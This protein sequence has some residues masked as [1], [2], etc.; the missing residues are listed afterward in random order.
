MRDVIYLFAPND[1]DDDD[2]VDRQSVVFLCS[3]FVVTSAPGGVGGG[4]ALLSVA[5]TAPTVAPARPPLVACLGASRIPASVAAAR[6][7]IMHVVLPPRPSPPT[8][9]VWV[10]QPSP[11]G[12]VSRLS[13]ALVTRAFLGSGRRG[14]SFSLL[15]LEDSAA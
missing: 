4:Q 1:D 9:V 14:R 15:P 13:A 12:N 6:H 8:C 11:G 7:R 10:G 2:Y 5:R 3:C